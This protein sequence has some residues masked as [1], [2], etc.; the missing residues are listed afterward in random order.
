MNLKYKAE[1]VEADIV[2]FGH[3][4]YPLCVQDEGVI[5]VNP[6]S[7]KQPRGY[8]VPTFVILNVEELDRGKSLSFHYYDPKFQEITSLSAMFE[9]IRTP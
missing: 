2:L 5:F 7:F 3:T 9:I 6:G 4:H 1:E 8:T